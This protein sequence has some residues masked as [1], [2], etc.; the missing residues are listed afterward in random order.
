MAYYTE[1][2]RETLSK[3][4]CKCSKCGKSILKGSPCIV[5][6]K[7]KTAHHKTCKS[8]ESVQTT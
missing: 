7:T 4:D 1:A 3:K 2:P 5:N 6:P 8:N